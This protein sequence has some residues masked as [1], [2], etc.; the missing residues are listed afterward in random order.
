LRHRRCMPLRYAALP[1]LPFMG[2]LLRSSA[3]L[4]AALRCAFCCA[5]LLGTSLPLQPPHCRYAAPRAAAALR[6]FHAALSRFLVRLAYV[7]LRC[8]CG[9]ALLRRTFAATFLLRLCCCYA[10]V[11]RCFLPSASMYYYIHLIPIFFA[12]P[13][14]QLQRTTCCSK[15]TNPSKG[16]KVRS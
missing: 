8:G 5:A 15:I 9:T 3:A 7:L 1:P 6:H 10:G 16:P 12:S 4:L 2:Y 13:T 14:Q 11:R